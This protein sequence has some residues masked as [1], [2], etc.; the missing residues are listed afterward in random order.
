MTR[1]LSLAAAALV[2]LATASPAWAQGSLSGRAMGQVLDQ[3]GRAIK[4]AIVRATN[5]QAYPPEITSTTD[6]KGR[7]AMIGLRT[8]V[9]TF[10]IE[11]PGYVTFTGSYPMRANT[12]PPPFR[13]SLERT[14]E[15]IPGALPRDIDEQLSRAQALRNEGRFDQALDAYQSIYQKHPKL[16]TLNLVIG[17]VY[18]Q[19]AEREADAAAR[20]ALYDRAV[21]AYSEV[22]KSDP[23]TSAAE[24]AA[25]QIQSLKK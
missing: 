25:A 21:A 8:G 18:Q 1:L 13:V 9:W 20:Q 4:G 19:K 11:A 22:I 14:L 7:F 2:L 16:T 5:R 6:D 17:S 10:S 3:S 12:P 24:E 15:P 23:E